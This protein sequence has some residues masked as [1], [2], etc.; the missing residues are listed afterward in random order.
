MNLT[1]R[2]MRAFVEVTRQGSFTGA[3]RELS[4][5]QSAVSALV[6]DLEAQL[7]LVVLD[8]TTRRVTLTDAGTHLLQLAERVL[9]DVE[10]AVT[11]AKGLLDKSIGRVVIAA[12]PLAAATLLPQMIS[13]FSKHHPKVIV[14]L[15]DVLTDDILQSVRGGTADMGVGT[16]ERSTTELELSTLYEDVLGAVLPCSSPLATRKVLRWRDL[17]GEAMI[18]LSRSSA[19]RPLIDSVLASQG[20]ALGQ[21]RFEVG[22]MGTAVALVEAGLGISVLPERAAALIKSPDTC[23]KRLTAPVVTR[24][25]TLV[26]RAGRTLSPA[27]VAFVEY[28]SQHR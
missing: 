21:R 22:Y 9:R 15:H 13:L 10:T 20:I 23:F 11:E 17:E 26:T 12:S 6:R 27:A 4:L 16:F 7:G 24:P 5:T 8:R 28:L 25:V 2:Q 1:L 19:F 3:A 18:G 14:E